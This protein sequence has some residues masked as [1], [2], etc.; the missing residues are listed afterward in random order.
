[1]GIQE[2][3][4]IIFNA[5]L[6]YLMCGHMHAVVR[7]GL[8]GRLVGVS[9]L[10]SC[11]PSAWGKGQLQGA[12]SDEPSCWPSVRLFNVERYTLLFRV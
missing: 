12:S 3:V 6:I 10:L 1:M 8:R 9:A 2:G 5:I 4:G 11:E 7:V